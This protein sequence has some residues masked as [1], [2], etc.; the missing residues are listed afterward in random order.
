MTAHPRVLMSS[1][2]VLCSEPVGPVACSHSPRPAQRPPPVVPVL[3]R[4]L[5][6]QLQAA[7]VRPQGPCTLSLISLHTPQ[8]CNEDP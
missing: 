5:S 7:L 1:T 2:A 3:L 4:R 8:T 6:R